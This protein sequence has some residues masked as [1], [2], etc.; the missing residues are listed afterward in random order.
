METGR[1]GW[2][3]QSAGHFVL[4]DLLFCST[5]A[6]P[7]GNECHRASGCPWLY[8]GT[9]IAGCCCGCKE[10]GLAKFLPSPLGYSQKNSNFQLNWNF[11]EQIGWESEWGHPKSCF[12]LRRAQ[13]NKEERQKEK[14]FTQCLIGGEWRGGEFTVSQVRPKEC[15]DQKKLCGY[16][17]YKG[18]IF[19]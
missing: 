1:T 17:T 2:N 12:F 15:I 13:I 19:L 9:A 3:R 8:G 6:E 18:S 4:R 10:D 7:E 16:M 14:N 11:P 5:D